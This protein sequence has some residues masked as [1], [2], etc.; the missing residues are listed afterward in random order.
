MAEETSPFLW[1]GA[2]ALARQGDRTVE[3]FFK[4]GRT[5]LSRIITT[6]RGARLADGVAMRHLVLG[7]IVV[8]LASVTI[9]A[10]NRS[11]LDSQ[12]AYFRVPNTLPP[13]GIATAVTQFAAKSRVL[14]GFE[15]TSDCI[16]GSSFPR[17]DAASDGTDLGGMTVRTALDHLMTL[18]PNYRWSEMNGVA[19]VRPVASWTDAANALNLHVQPFYIDNATVSATLATLLGVPAHENPNDKRAFSVAFKGGTM[20]EGL[21]ALIRAHEGR[22]DAGLIVH[23]S[24]SG[25]DESPTFNVSIA[26]N[27][28]SV[29]MGTP[30]PRLLAVRRAR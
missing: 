3:Q 4:H 26:F 19:V 18:S 30:L 17:L 20:V 29:V 6:H 13:C 28:S 27:G 5:P 9:G 8:A 1:E 10:Q 12:A 16:G 23:P 22:W 2:L 11:P 24:A 14:M 7:V 21:N 15:R 25:I